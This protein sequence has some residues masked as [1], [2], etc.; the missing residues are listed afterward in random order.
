MRRLGLAIAAALVASACGGDNGPTGP[1]PLA[2]TPP[3][4]PACQANN[5]AAVSFGIGRVL[6]LRV[7]SGTAAGLPL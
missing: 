3:P 5:T 7:F 6:L 2:A 1:S 4:V